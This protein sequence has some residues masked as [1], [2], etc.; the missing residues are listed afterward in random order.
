MILVAA[1]VAIAVVHAL[2]PDHYMPFVAMGRLKRW[3]LRKTLLF[4]CI[5]GTVHVFSSVAL[6]MLLISGIDLLGYASALE[7]LSP[8]L[9]ISIGVAY[10]LLSLTSGHAHLSANSAAALLLA[11]G[12]SPCL[13]LV[14]LLLSARGGELLSVAAAFAVATLATIL[15]LTYLSFTA[16][17]PPRSLHGRE[18]VAAGIVI[19]LTGVVTYFLGQMPRNALRKFTGG[20]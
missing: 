20:V 19:A 16:F 13:P 18:D 15:L 7:N 4:S 5:A 10:A 1:A 9:L 3:S 17:K 11:L 14:P 2:A 12:L 6:G 8:L